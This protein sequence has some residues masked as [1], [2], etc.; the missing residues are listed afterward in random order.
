MSLENAN[1]FMN[2]LKE[3]ETLQKRLADLTPEEKMDAAKELGQ[4]FT[5]D[6]LKEAAG[7][8]LPMEEMG[9]VAGGVPLPF[10]S[11]DPFPAEKCPDSP[12]GDH[13]W[14]EMAVFTEYLVVKHHIMKCRY[15]GNTRDEV[16]LW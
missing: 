1:K 13:D 16:G 9:K 5:I 7:H 11:S 6:E 8:N 15:C 3:D 2:L 4:D 12:T 10:D 14:K